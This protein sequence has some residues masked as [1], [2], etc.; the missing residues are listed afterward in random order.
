MAVVAPNHFQ[1]DGAC[2]H[3]LLDA[4]HAALAGFGARRMK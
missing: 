3:I 1:N 4:V 2:D